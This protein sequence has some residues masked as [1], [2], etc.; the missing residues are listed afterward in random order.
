LDRLWQQRIETVQGAAL[1]PAKLVANAHL[2]A[3]LEL[4]P[5]EPRGEVP[6]AKECRRNNKSVTAPPT[7]RARKIS[8]Q[9]IGLRQRQCSHCRVLAQQ[10]TEPQPDRYLRI[11]AVGGVVFVGI[12]GAEIGSRPARTM[13][14]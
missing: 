8:R 13:A 5:R 6:G 12:S 10:K 4:V 1:A 9:S 2:V 11:P 7:P 3:G 14:R